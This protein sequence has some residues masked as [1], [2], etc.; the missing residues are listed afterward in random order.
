MSKWPRCPK[1]RSQNAELIEIW[2]AGITW[3]PGDPYYNEGVLEPGDPVKVEGNCLDC[4]HKWA[5]RGIT[6]V[7]PE[8]FDN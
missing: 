1:C 8:W 3:H 2:D 5:M 6:Q 7:K 4:E